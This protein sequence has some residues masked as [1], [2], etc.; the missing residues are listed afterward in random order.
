MRKTVPQDAMLIPEEAERVFKGVIFDVYHWQQELFDGSKVTFER[1][2][3]PD[4]VLF[5]A[6]KDGKL[7]M[8]E[9]EQ[10]GR[11][12]VLRAPGGR[13]DPGET[14]QQA[15]KRECAEEIGMRFK[16]WRLVDV[17]QPVAKI[18]WFVATFVASELVEE[19]EPHADPGE[20][21]KIVEQTLAEAKKTINRNHPLTAYTADLISSLSS[22]EGLVTLPEFK[23]KEVDATDR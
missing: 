7:V 20:R 15:A 6:V 9:D 1:L 22:L 3:R 14:W 19:L 5:L 16:N 21:I 18:D 13:V 23:G 4:T 2:K 11:P 12:P 10:P 17:V 8:I